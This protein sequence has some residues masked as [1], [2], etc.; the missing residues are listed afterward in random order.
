MGKI[1]KSILKFI[2]IVLFVCSAALN[3]I[4]FNSSYGSLIFKYDENKFLAMNENAQ[5]KIQLSNLLSKKDAGIQFEATNT[6]GCKEYS[7]QYYIDDKSKMTF[8]TECSYSVTINKEV[9]NYTKKVYFK[10]DKV[11]IEDKGEKSSQDMDLTTALTMHT[12]IAHYYTYLT[13]NTS[14]VKESKA[15]TGLSISFS[16]LYLI[17]IS[18]SH[19][20]DAGTKF[21][22]DYDSKG[23]LRKV[24][25]VGKDEN[26]KTIE[27][28][29][30]ISYKNNK[31]SFP[32]LKDFE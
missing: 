29:F 21:K 20:D 6:N 14:L 12:S 5:D 10:D 24:E 25:I 17:G 22:Y 27:R 11:Y 18:Y 13:L 28:N 7:A 31:I 3:I 19:K 9:K 30:K 23:N 15:K 8:A 2:L 26:D 4:M 32:S 1:I 16:P